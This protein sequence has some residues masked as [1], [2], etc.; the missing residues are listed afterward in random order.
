MSAAIL[1]SRPDCEWTEA[2]LPCGERATTVDHIT[3]RA[4]GGTDDPSNLRALCRP[5]HAKVSGRYA[6]I[7]KAR[8]RGDVA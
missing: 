4:E 3:P 7:R 1:R 8:L 2:V 6:A 5:H